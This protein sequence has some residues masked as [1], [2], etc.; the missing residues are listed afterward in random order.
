M[1]I[2]KTRAISLLL[3][4]AVVS[5]SHAADTRW[6]ASWTSSPLGGKIV[7]RGGAAGQDPALTHRPWDAPVSTAFEPGR[8]AI[9][10]APD[11]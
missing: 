4:L 10:V 11:E 3:A 9:G 6:I 7:I 5:I 1:K 2:T 8:Y